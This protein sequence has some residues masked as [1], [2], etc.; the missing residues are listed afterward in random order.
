MKQYTVQYCDDPDWEKLPRAEISTEYRG[1]YPEVSAYA[2]LCFD[3]E[4]L[5]V[6]LYTKEK[7]YVLN[8]SGALGSPCRDSC[9]EFFFCPC[10]GDTR[11]FNIEF[12][13][14]S[15]MFL[16]LGSGIG[17]LVRLFPFAKGDKIFSPK[18]V[19]GEDHWEVFYSVGFEFI[20]RFFPDFSIRT[21]TE[22]RANFYKCSE[23]GKQPHFLSWNPVV[24]DPFTFHTP[25]CFGKLLFG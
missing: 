18:I 12:N 1:A 5:L 20:K 19:K 22:L 3:R 8:E 7:D 23:T 24:A 21:G 25:S 15:C 9:L 11:Y 17:D 6:H 14:G 16:G 4:A 10:P 13:S 2:Q